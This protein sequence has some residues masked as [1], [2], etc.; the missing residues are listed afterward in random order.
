MEF[1]AEGFEARVI[2]HE[3][4]HLEGVLIVDRTTPERTRRGLARP[5][6]ERGAGVFAAAGGL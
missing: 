4:D 5:A 1:D 2:Q 3:N 6:R